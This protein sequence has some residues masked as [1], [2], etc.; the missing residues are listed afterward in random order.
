[1]NLINNDNYSFLKSRVNLLNMISDLYKNNSNDANIVTN[2]TDDY[3]EQILSNAKITTDSKIL[4]NI[5]FYI[6]IHEIFLML[7][8]TSYVNILIPSE[9]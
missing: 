3:K 1:M 8:L 5:L 7:H 4:V 2:F 9:R 6:F